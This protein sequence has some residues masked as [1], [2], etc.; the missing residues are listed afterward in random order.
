MSRPADWWVLDLDEDPTP[1]EPVSVRRLASRFSEFADDVV[2]AERQVLGLGGDSVVLT[3]I[4][5]SGDAFRDEVGELPEQLRKLHTSYRMAGDAL[6]AYAPR[7]AG[8]QDQADRALAA[9]REARGRADAARGQLGGAQDWLSRAATTVNSYDG[10]PSD[11]PPADPEQVRSAIRNQQAAQARVAAVQ[12]Q[13]RD[14]EADLDAARRLALDAK[15]LRLGAARETAQRINEASDAGI[16]NKPWCSWEKVSGFVGELW[17]DLVAACKIVVLVL[18]I[19][20]L[21]I[22]GPLAWIV[23]A[24]ALVVLA[25][26]L[27]KYA[28]GEA[29]LWD[30]AFAVLDCIPGTKGLTTATRLA[31]GIKGIA[32]G[33]LPE[34]AALGRRALPALGRA[35]RRSA[36]ALGELHWGVYRFVMNAPA[37]LARM[38][39]HVVHGTPGAVRAY[40]GGLGDGWR[41]GRSLGHNPLHALYDSID[42]ADAA[43]GTAFKAGFDDYVAQLQT[44]G[45]PS[46]VASMVQGDSAYPGIDN[47]IDTALPEGTLIEGGFPGPSG[48]AAPH[49]TVHSL[50]D[51]ASAY[52]QGV[53]VGPSANPAHPDYRNQVVT[54][55]INTPDLPVAESYTWANTQYGAGGLRQF[56]IPDHANQVV[57][58]NIDALDSAGNVIPASL[59]ADGRLKLDAPRGSLTTLAGL[60]APL[61]IPSTAEMQR[62]LGDLRRLGM[63][64]AGVVTVPWDWQ[65]VTQQP[66]T[67]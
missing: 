63:I 26:T 16:Q 59:G 24:A 9:G 60:D 62:R 51:D 1:G 8:A 53:Q 42:A 56:H 35:G 21:I 45:R 61:G 30:V 55:R 5:L 20:V 23:L 10:R 36:D 66:A 37:K 52:Y 22:G 57:S 38:T 12:G 67:P 44:S 41:I 3:W 43:R 31:A 34:L 28:R 27:M 29:S 33:G 46:R 32:R 47:W 54:Y 49:G 19:V 50:G 4:G 25:D 39:A 14:A 58:G 40:A 6:D 64:S 7:L 48:F 15:E 65:Q 13:L 17:E 11:A 18:G 2:R